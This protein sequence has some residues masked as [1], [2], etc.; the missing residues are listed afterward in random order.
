L[1][2]KSYEARRKPNQK[3]RWQGFADFGRRLPRLP[4]G[5][6]SLPLA[7]EGRRIMPGIER[8]I[9]LGRVKF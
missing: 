4:K 2:L 6:E 1:L 8:L 5:K 7:D 3:N 9:V